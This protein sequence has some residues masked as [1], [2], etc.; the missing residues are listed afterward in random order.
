MLL[1]LVVGPCLALWVTRFF[2]P[3]EGWVAGWVW[4]GWVGGF[5]LVAGGNLQISTTTG[6]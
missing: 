2:H 3:K 5:L 1:I 4:L 6:G